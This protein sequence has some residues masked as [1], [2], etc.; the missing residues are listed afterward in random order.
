MS[1]PPSWI[2]NSNIPSPSPV[3][4]QV[5]DV[6]Y[7][8]DMTMEDLADVISF[9]AGLTARTLRS[10]NSAFSRPVSE[11]TTVL[12]AIV[13]IGLLPTIHIITAT[14][15]AAVFFS[16]PGNYGDMK[17]HWNHHILVASLAEAHAKHFNLSD[18]GRWFVG[19]LIHDIGRLMML[20]VDPVKYAQ[21]IQLHDDEQIDLREAEKLLFDYSHDIAGGLLLD[22]WRFPSDLADAAY[23]HHKEFSDIEDFC[24]GIGIANQ[25]A[26]AIQNNL[27]LPEFSGIPVPDIII[28]ANERYELMKKVSGFC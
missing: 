5:F 19:G 22:F 27:P 28:A 15:V 9:D 6:L 2:R 13:R 10:A 4:N 20:K 14:E 21:A 11:I 8:P 1:L 3:L 24:S 17:Y 25:V 16:V 12:D 7:N 18:P 23:E 26:N